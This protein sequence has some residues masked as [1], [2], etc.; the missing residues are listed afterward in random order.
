MRSENKKGIFFS[1]LRWLKFSISFLTNLNITQSA[2]LLLIIWCDSR[3]FVLGGMA[4][5]TS[6]LW[7]VGVTWILIPYTQM[8]VIQPLYY[9]INNNKTRTFSF[10][11]SSTCS[12]RLVVSA[13]CIWPKKNQSI[14]EITNKRDK[15]LCQ[16]ASNN[17]KKSKLAGDHWRIT[18][19]WKLGFTGTVECSDIFYMKQT[20]N[21]QVEVF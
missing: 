20:L 5:H 9:S 7:N 1:F 19:G 10:T 12:C 15:N 8:Y 11:C 13:C 18:S 4:W 21:S 17:R 6:S 16:P 3:N 2:D 14:E